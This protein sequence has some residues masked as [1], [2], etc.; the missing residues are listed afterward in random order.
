[1]SKKEQLKEFDIMIRIYDKKTK[2]PVFQ[3]STP[4]DY[5]KYKKI[6]NILN[7]NKC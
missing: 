7:D 4:V 1:M 5:K 2:Y 6:E 3:T